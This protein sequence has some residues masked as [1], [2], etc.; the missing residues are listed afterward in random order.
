MSGFRSEI[1]LVSIR[2]G[3][4]HSGQDKE[5]A[6]NG[7]PVLG[8]IR[9]AIIHERNESTAVFSLGLFMN[10]EPDAGN[11]VLRLPAVHS[12]VSTIQRDVI[13]SLDAPFAETAMVSL[14]GNCPLRSR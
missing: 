11:A 12:L 7:D 2:S 9:T 3:W 10:H 8:S 5:S 1:E 13:S 14:A 6:C 4:C